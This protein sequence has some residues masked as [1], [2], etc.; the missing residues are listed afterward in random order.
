MS[1]LPSPRAAPAAHLDALTHLTERRR[2]RFVA[3]FPSQCDAI[4]SLIDK[5][6]AG[7]APGPVLKLRQLANRLVE[8]AGLGGFAQVSAAATALERV[9]NSSI[10]DMFD[11]ALAKDLVDEMHDALACDL[12]TQP[13][14]ATEVARVDDDPY[15]P[16]V[17]NILIVDDHAM[18]RGG[19]RALL[20]DGFE[21]VT[22]DEAP[23]GAQALTRLRT[24]PCDIVLLD[25]SLPGR[26]G[27][28][29]LKEVKAEWPRLAVLVLT[30]HRED[31]LA[32]RA[33]KAGASG[34]LT[35]ECAPEE[36]VRAVRKILNGGR[37]VSEALAEQLAG[38]AGYDLQQRPHD[39]LSDREY[40]VMCRL[41][42]AKTVTEIAEE[43]CLSVKTISTYRARVL[44]K[45]RL[46]NNAAIAQY[47]HRHSLVC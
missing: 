16:P 47:A 10:G 30:G 38:E 3:T 18:L 13:Q 1:A 24:R 31:E 39:A 15:A 23:D 43:M 8:L 21:S 46:R 14:A 29:L 42:A 36:L 45:M 28:D 44:Q 19:L 7:D 17:L 32:I 40:D 2:Q 5:V 34:Y 22:F 26:N 12:A 33:L 25:L 6:D 4:L 9:I 41:A 11:A 27:L 37:Y 35:K 20:R